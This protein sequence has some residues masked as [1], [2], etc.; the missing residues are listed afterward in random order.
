M[1]EIV[2]KCFFKCLFLS[3]H[4]LLSIDYITF[5]IYTLL[6]NIIIY[7]L[8]LFIIY[9]LWLYIIIYTLWWLLE[10]YSGVDFHYFFHGFE[11]RDF[12]LLYWLLL[13]IR[14]PSLH[15]YLTNIW[16][17][18]RRHFPRALV[19]IECNRLE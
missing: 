1:N 6:L 15:Y 4:R 14:D 16:G 13:R 11:W 9:T 5:I 17:K 3:K 12:F 18:G 8:L 10:K 2:N 7:A 19:E